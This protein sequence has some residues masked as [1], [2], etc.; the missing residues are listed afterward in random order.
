MEKQQKKLLKLRQ[1]QKKK[2]MKL[3]AKK[4]KQE[5]KKQQKNPNPEQTQQ[6]SIQSPQKQQVVEKKYFHWIFVKLCD[7]YISLKSQ[8]VFAILSIKGTQMKKSRSI[9]IK[10]GSVT[11]DQVFNFG[12]INLNRTVNIEIYQKDTENESIIGSTEISLI[13][14]KENSLV[15]KQIEFTNLDGYF[16]LNIFYKKFLKTQSLK[17]KIKK[18]LKK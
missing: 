16:K 9:Q 6:P 5:K 7:A 18:I 12:L 8:N 1:K 13:D 2:L 4:E 17:V 11:W 10:D 3:K 15:N 14:L